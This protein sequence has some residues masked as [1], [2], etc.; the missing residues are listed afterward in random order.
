M[1]PSLDEVCYIVLRHRNHLDIMSSQPITMPNEQP[2]DFSASN[3]MVM[4]NNQLIK[5]EQ[6]SIY[7]MKAGDFDANGIVT[8]EDY[9]L[10]SNQA[11]MIGQYNSCD[12]NLDKGVTTGDFNLYRSNVSVIGVSHVRYE[13]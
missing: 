4:G 13:E 6:D 5:F 3:E 7:A 12:C 2:Y 1:A 11:S 10:Y 9:N 8:V